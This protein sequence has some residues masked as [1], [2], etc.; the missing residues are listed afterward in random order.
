MAAEQLGCKAG[1]GRA[2]RAGGGAAAAVACAAMCSDPAAA[3]ASQGCQRYAMPL[4]TSSTHCPGAVAL[5]NAPA[6]LRLPAQAAVN[7]RR[8]R[9][10]RGLQRAWGPPRRATGL[11]GPTLR[12]EV[13]P[14]RPCDTARASRAS[15]RPRPRMWEWAPIRSMRVRSLTSAATR[16]SA[17]A[18][19]GARPD[20]PALPSAALPSAWTDHDAS[21]ACNC[22]GTAASGGGSAHAAS[23][24]SGRGACLNRQPGEVLGTSSLPCLPSFSCT[25]TSRSPWLPRL[26]RPPARRRPRPRSPPRRRRRRRHVRGAHL[27]LISGEGGLE[28]G[29]ALQPQPGEAERRGGGD[30][31]PCGAPPPSLW[32]G[33][34]LGGHGEGLEGAAR[35]AAPPARWGPCSL[36]A[37]AHPGPCCRPR[38][39]HVGDRP[40]MQRR[41]ARAGAGQPTAARQH[42]RPALAFKL[43]LAYSAVGWPSLP[44]RLMVCRQ[45]G[46]D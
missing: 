18:C 13:W 35:P 21:S 39:P 45:P 46:P 36:S 19:Q 37:P 1:G 5:A 9:Q 6:A 2:R 4:A 31:G 34:A 27:P 17:I 11:P 44:R 38:Q 12:A 25:T 22:K 24:H 33:P 15:S 3:V 14:T 40:H 42:R 7:E 20:R 43:Q 32:P 28:R 30:G 41:T 10:R 16:K 23:K 26:R 29:P 8:R